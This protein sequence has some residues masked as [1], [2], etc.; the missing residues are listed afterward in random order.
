MGFPP[1]SLFNLFHAT[2]EMFRSQVVFLHPLWQVSVVLFCNPHL[3]VC[4]F[5]SSLLIGHVSFLVVSSSKKFTLKIL[6]PMQSLFP[7][8]RSNKPLWTK[9]MSLDTIMM[10]EGNNWKMIM[11]KQLRR[12][13]K[14][15]FGTAFHLPQDNYHS[16]GIACLTALRPPILKKNTIS[17]MCLKCLLKCCDRA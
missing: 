7:L 11:L 13:S 4:T 10:E 2:S 14:L 17:L 15:G 6:T 3:W 12:R 16:E 8:R 5:E 1:I 9:V